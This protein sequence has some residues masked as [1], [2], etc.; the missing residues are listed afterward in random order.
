MYISRT[1]G[2]FKDNNGFLSV[3]DGILAIFIVFIALFS[4]SMIADLQIPSYSYESYDFKSSNDVLELMTIKSDEN[5][6]S[7]L[8]NIVFTIENS[9]N[10]IERD[11]KIATI[12]SKYLNET[13]SNYNYLFVEN[14]ILNTTISSKGDI[15]TVSDINSATRTFGDYSFTLFLF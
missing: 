10:P 12:A 15:S 7:I 5:S 1:K 11:R 8:E 3:L 14:N 2:M 9:D 6:Y 13:T 4:F